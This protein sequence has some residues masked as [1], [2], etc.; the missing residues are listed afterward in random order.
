MKNFIDDNFLL[1]NET[2]KRLYGYAKDL[3]IIDY[4]CHINPQEIAEDRRFKNITELWLGGDHYKWR[5]MRQNGVS[6]EFITGSAP[7]RDKFQKWAE[8]LEK[9]AGNPIY[10]WSHLELRRYFGYN[11]I[12]NGETAD[13]IWELCNEK[14]KRLSARKFI[15]LSNVELICTTD[16]PADDLNWHRAI[17]ADPD[18]KV[19][20]P[21]SFRPDKALNAEND[22]FASYIAALS[23][24]AETE[25]KTF[26]D[27]KSALRKRIEYFNGL[28]CRTADHG[29][30]KTMYSPYGE[31]EAE[32]IFAAAFRGEKISLED[33]EKY[34]TALLLFLGG[35]Y[36][37][38][39]WVMQL[40]YG[41]DRNVNS[42]MFKVLG[43][44]TGFDCI[45][46]D[47]SSRF[48]AQL[49]NG[50]GARLPKTIVYSLD[51]SENTAIDSICG[52]F[53][54]VRH[55]A[56]WWFNDNKT[57]I[58]EQLTSSANQGLLGNFIGMLTDSRSFLSYTRHEYF[59]RI[60]CNFLGNLVEKG[61][62]PSDERALNKI[63]R[64][65]CH[66]NA[67]NFFNF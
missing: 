7:D 65:V 38:H 52:C 33:S 37:K 67:V 2:A 48:L 17:A 51:P 15:E 25:I 58:L 29:L 59:R 26:A 39:G 66:D 18:F 44:D 22:G 62:Y 5:L 13:E 8:T 53:R 54:D 12:L 41:C 64:G 43:T 40:H 50:F 47:S 63:V 16:D 49:L 10:V 57:G 23:Q 36:K 19:K 42:K 21:P 28:G 3:P 24:A 60:F 30:T 9:A 34:K 14:L 55:G 4:H 31:I 56:A 11:G 46:P 6:E 20:V 32:W 61:E 1:E 27:L 35:E 45:N